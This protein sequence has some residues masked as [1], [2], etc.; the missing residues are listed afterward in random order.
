MQWIE[1]TPR[2]GDLIRTKVSF[3]YHYGIFADENR[4]IQFG[5]PDNV[6]LPAEQVRVL[7]SDI[8]A[9]LRGGDLEVGKPDRQEKKRLRPAGQIVELAMSRIG[10]GGYDI[11]HNNCEHFVNECAFGEATSSFVS[12]VRQ[13]LRKKLGK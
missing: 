4:V 12:G 2:Y 8:Y 9:F 3:Y 13:A 1:G 11:I 5:M 7:C 6:N 10:E